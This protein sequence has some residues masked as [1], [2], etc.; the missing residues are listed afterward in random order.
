MRGVQAPRILDELWREQAVWSQTANRMRHQI[1]RARTASLVLAITA[2]S[3]GAAAG[4]TADDRPAVA[5]AL[6]I[7]AALAAALL[8]VLRP[9]WSGAA[10]QNWTRAR[11]TSEALKSQIYLWL[12]KGEQHPD[13]PDGTRLDEAAAALLDGVADLR[14]HV[15]DERPATREL[16][17]VQDPR[18]YFE[19]RVLDQI[20]GY[21]RPKAA[22]LQGRLRKLNRLQVGVA[23]V[24]AAIAAVAAVLGPA[25]ATW[26]AVATTIGTSLTVHVQ[27]TQYEEQQIKF[28]Q[29]ADRLER[30]NRRAGTKA[31]TDELLALAVEAERIIT[32]ENEGWMALLNETPPD[33]DLG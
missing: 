19:V 11:A 5:T 23:L 21:Y 10:L 18:S 30:V 13:D 33:H 27:A 6:A 15:R 31:S 32:A 7:A 1:E 4:A 12:A 28:L 29:T 26:V 17:A 9:A 20:E 25:A 3:A 24:G 8:P 2:A 14:L 22:E 16:P